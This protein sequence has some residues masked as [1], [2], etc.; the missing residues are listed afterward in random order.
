MGDEEDREAVA[1][2]VLVEGGGGDREGEGGDEKQK[3]SA[4]I[5]VDSDSQQDGSQGGGRVGEP[6]GAGVLG[7]GIETQEE[8]VEG[9]NGVEGEE[10]VAVVPVLDE[11]GVDFGGGGGMDK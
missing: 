9:G 3:F 2:G 6:H 5:K 10:G 1:E 8:P 4:A 11:A 7:D